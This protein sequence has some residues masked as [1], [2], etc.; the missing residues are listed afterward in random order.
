MEFNSIFF[1]IFFFPVSIILYYLTPSK[2][3]P[4][5]LLVI[6][7]VYCGLISLYLLILVYILTAVNYFSAIFIEKNSGITKR[8]IIY[9]FS[10]ILDLLLLLILKTKSAISAVMPMYAENI[11]LPICVSFFMLEFIGYISD[12]YNKKI[13]GEKNFINFALYIL[14]FPKFIMGSVVSY[15]HFLPFIRRSQINLSI[16]GKGI[17]IFIKGLSKN[18]I[19]GV[20]LYPLWVTVKNIQPDRL[21]SLSALLGIAAFSLSFYFCISGILDMSSGISYCFG[22]KFPHDFDHPFFT[23]GLSEFSSKWHI[24]TVKWFKKYVLNPLKRFSVPFAIIVTWVLIG[25]WYEFSWNKLMWGLIIGSAAALEKF[26]GR[27]NAVCTFIVVSLGWI[28]FSQSSLGDSL[29]FIKA[30]LGGNH[31]FADSLSFYLLKSYIVIIL[32]AIY[33]STDL[34]KNLTEKIKDSQ[35]FAVPLNMAMPVMDLI[36]LIIDISI[37]SSGGNYTLAEM[38]G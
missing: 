11:F 17:S 35:Y 25:L 19:I 31:G 27:K 5:A 22:Y 28:F 23:Y 6:S 2:Y 14:F 38:F 36:L 4:L 9:S 18:I 8:R 10:V 24:N 3:K 16:L 32:I 33:T 26:S 37:I 12:V 15:Q 7:S 34:F 20:S 13:F 29:L 30:I 1:I 21:S